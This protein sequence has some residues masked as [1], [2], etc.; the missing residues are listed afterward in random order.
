MF[1]KSAELRKKSCRS[2]QNVFTMTIKINNS[3]ISS[4]MLIVILASCGGVPNTS[5]SNS[6]LNSSK[7]ALALSNFN[8]RREIAL[9]AISKGEQPI[10]PA[11]LN[12]IQISGQNGSMLGNPGYMALNN[13]LLLGN[14][15]CI[16]QLSPSDASTFYTP[17][18]SVTIETTTSKQT[19]SQQSAVAASLSGGFGLFTAS[20]SSAITNSSLFNNTS[21]G[22]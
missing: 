10:I 4:V 20:T 7:D 11:E 1:L 14:P 18:Q 6:N 19:G 5:N 22:F 16:N 9:K 21:V 15:T 2:M 12:I 3:F 17:S 8:S 13:S